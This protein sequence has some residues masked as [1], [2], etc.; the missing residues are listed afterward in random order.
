MNALIELLLL[1]LLAAE[2]GQNMFSHLVKQ[3]MCDFYVMFM[4]F[5]IYLNSRC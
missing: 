4:A 2:L 3:W 5:V 1:F